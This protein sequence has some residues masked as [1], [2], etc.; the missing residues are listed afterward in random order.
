MYR[1]KKQNFYERLEV[2]PSASPF[3]ICHAYRNALVIY[4]DESLASYS[5]FLESERK[6]LLALLEEAFSTLVNEQT[7]NE[8][9][10][11]LVVKGQLREEHRYKKAAGKPVPI[12]AWHQ[13]Q[14]ASLQTLNA[15]GAVHP[16]LEHILAGEILTG[17]DLQRIRTGMGLSLEHIAARTKIRVTLLQFIE[18][19]EF[20]KLPSRFHLKSYLTQYVQCLHLDT[21]SVVERYLKRIRD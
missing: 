8:Y 5:F 20:D 3:E 21:A 13:S 7:R 19:D 18:E 12:F 16:D 4:G 6:E 14:D 2:A 9:D 10:Q 11:R 1:F 17:S 15:D